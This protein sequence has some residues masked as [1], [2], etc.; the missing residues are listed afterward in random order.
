MADETTEAITDGDIGVIV[1][2]YGAGHKQV[3]LYFDGSTDP[4]AIFTLREEWAFQLR[5]AIFGER[6]KA[7]VATLTAERDRL[8]L[9]AGSGQVEIDQLRADVEHMRGE[10]DGL[11]AEVER[12]RSYWAEAATERDALAARLAQ[13]GRVVEAARDWR[14]WS[15]GS[16]DPSITTAE[17]I[18]LY[19]E[20]IEALIAAVDALD[21]TAGPGEEVV[22]PSES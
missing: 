19:E 7:E 20:A 22:G 14:R 15:N 11:R 6:L 2:P 10:R 21:G 5:D 16:S 17:V 4:A 13:A 1:W 12:K 8:A 9:Q 18:V 3:G